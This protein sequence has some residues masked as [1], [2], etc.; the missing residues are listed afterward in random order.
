MFWPKL[1]SVHF[2]IQSQSP[3]LRGLDNV[4][5]ACC[6]CFD[7]LASLGDQLSNLGMG[8]TWEKDVQKYLMTTKNYVKCKFS[9]EVQVSDRCPSHCIN[10]ALSDQKEG[11]FQ[12]ECDH[13]L[14]QVP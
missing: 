10:F 7:D 2:V 5:E 1:R 4:K 3:I 12:E 14:V 9:Y 11:A 8:S 6:R 13:P